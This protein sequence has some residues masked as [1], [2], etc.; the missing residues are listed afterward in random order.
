MMSFPRGRA[1]VGLLSLRASA[2]SL[3]I[4]TIERELRNGRDTFLPL[5]GALLAILLL[6]GF[7]TTAS[8]CLAAIGTV[9]VCIVSNGNSIFISAITVGT[10]MALALS[11][12][13]G[14]SIDALLFGRR[15][16]TLPK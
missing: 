13:G 5:L 6:A 14:Y 2:A 9:G 11:G 10:C 3:I 16:I 8:S 15:R 7:L 1:G 4:A 12:P